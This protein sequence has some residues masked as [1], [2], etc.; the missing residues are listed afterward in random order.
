MGFP[1]WLIFGIMPSMRYLVL[2]TSVMIQLCLGGLYAWSSFVPALHDKH[3]LTTAQTQLIF[4]L[5][6][7]VFTVAMVF[8]GRLLDRTGPRLVAIIGGL[9]FGVGYV[10]ASFSHDNFWLLL[11]GIGVVSGIGTGFGYVCPLATCVQ[12]FPNHKGLVTG[13]SV[14]GF[15]GGA[16]VLSGVAEYWLGQGVDVLVLLRWVGLVW[17]GVIVLAALPLHAPVGGHIGSSEHLGS[18]RR[19]LG[20]RFFLAL[21]AGMFCG[22]FAGLLVIGNLKPLA[23]SDGIGAV[24]AAAAISLFAVGNAAGRITWGWI[25]DKLGEKSIGLSLLLLAGAV[26]ALLAVG[27]HA[28]AFMAITA[29]IGFGFGACFVVYAAAVAHRYGPAMVGKL[30]PLVFLAYGLAGITGPALGGWLYDATGQYTHAILASTGILLV[31]LILAVVLLRSV[32]SA[33]ADQQPA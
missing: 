22:T 17:G 1:S 10:I 24:Q 20:D 13:I 15:G 31:G 21:L 26:A 4:G 27:S 16:V 9:C 28:I 29:L 11:G 8:A 30:Y 14:A 23:L 12:W 18:I 33:P 6:I 32:D 7:A 3:G 2:T 19:R 5:L 25:A